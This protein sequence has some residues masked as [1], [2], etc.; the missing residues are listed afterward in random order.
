MNYFLGAIFSTDGLGE[1]QY[2]EP[3]VRFMNNI[4]VPATVVLAVAAA[5]MIVVFAWLIIKAEDGEK[6]KEMKKRM[7][8]LMITFITIT[9]LIWL[10]GLV[11]SNFG[12][13]MTSIRS[14]F[15]SL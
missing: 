10:F 9:I 6:A 5:I 15:G 7:I 3:V 13:I 11:I 14:V 4:I 8:G 1:Y 12:T 2:L